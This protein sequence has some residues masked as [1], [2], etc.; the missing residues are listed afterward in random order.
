MT[1]RDWQR[2]DAHA[3]GVFLNGQEIPD[4]DAAAA[5]DIVDDSFLL[6]FNA[7]HERDHVHAA[8][9]PLRRALAGRALDGVEPAARQATLV[10]ARARV[11]V[12]GRVP[13]L[14]SSL[15]RDVARVTDFRCDLP[16]PAD[17]G[18]RLPRGAG[19]RPLPARARCLAPLPLAVAAGARRLDARLRRRRPAP[20]LRGARRRGGVPRALRARGARRPARHRPEPHGD[21]RREPVLARPGAAQEVLRRRPATGCHR[22]FFDV[23]DLARRAGRG[24]GG[25]RDDARE[26]ARARPRR[27]SSTGCASTT[28][29][30]SRTRATTSSGCASAAPSHVWVEKIL[31]PGEQLRDWPVEGTTGYEFANDVTAPLRRPAPPRSR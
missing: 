14:R 19:A 13:Q 31:E 6:L 18:L 27:R 15:L 11:E 8:D 5:S 17:A 23:G 7:Y 9:A 4:D 1:Q 25:V 3:L 30:A 2:D 12:V 29:T 22:R 26:G 20:H 10:A 24:P 21:E 16:S 28:P